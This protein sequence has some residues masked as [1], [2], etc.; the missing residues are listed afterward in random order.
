M[1]IL[2]IVGTEYFDEVNCWLKK[3]CF[4]RY[5]E[6]CKQKN[7]NMLKDLPLK[8]TRQDVKKVKFLHTYVFTFRLK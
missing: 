7:V 3:N 4:G 5:Q 6:I 2:I 8:I 1:N